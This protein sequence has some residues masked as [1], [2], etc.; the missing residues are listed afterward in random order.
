MLQLNEETQRRPEP[1]A[2]VERPLTRLVLTGFMGAGKSTVGALVAESLG[3]RFIDLDQAIETACG[4]SVSE[5]FRDHG[6]AYFRARERESIEQLREAARVVLALGGGAVE[7][8]VNLS[9]LLNSPGTCLVYLD[10]PLSELLARLTK[11]PQTRPLLGAPEHLAARHQQRLEHYRA[12]HLAV[13]T[14]GLTPEEV[15]ARVLDRAEEEWRI[16]GRPKRT[17]GKQRRQTG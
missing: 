1:S 8:P 9:S 4:Q 7:D 2:K 10:A 11:T 6:E 5:I 15:A 16:E 12:A 13:V 17:D 3:W 14:S